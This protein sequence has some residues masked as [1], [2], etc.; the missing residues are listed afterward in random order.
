MSEKGGGKM[1]NQELRDEMKAGQVKQ[2]EVAEYMGISEF[3][4]SRWLR[5]ELTAEGKAQVKQA[6]N[7]IVEQKERGDADE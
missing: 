2:W 7:Q 4:L 5:K 3:T 1:S 6:I